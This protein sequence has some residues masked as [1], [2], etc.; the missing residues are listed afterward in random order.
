M[1]KKNKILIVEDT[2]EILAH[3]QEFMMMEGNEV[4]TAGNGAEALLQ[5]NNVLPDLIITDLLMPKMTGYELFKDLKKKD[6]W[7][8]IP[9]LVFSAKPLDE[10]MSIKEMGADL[11]VLKPS[12][13]ETLLHHV[14]ELLNKA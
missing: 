12:H 8:K 11:F 10:S 2:H 5:L 13:P 7:S 9:V 4:F 14:N 1:K 3:L 6:A